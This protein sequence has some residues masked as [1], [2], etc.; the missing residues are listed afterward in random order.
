VA[1][2]IVKWAGG[3]TRLV[4]E[5][6]QRIPN[7][8]RTYA[9]PFAGGAA[10]FF[11][12]AQG[13]DAGSR[14]VRRAV[15]ADQNEE[16]IACYRA[17]KDDVGAVIDALG[18]YRYDKDLFYETRDRD[19]AK[20]DDVER[21]ARLL[22]LNRTCFNGLWRVN[23]SGRFNV[24]FGRYKNPRIVDEVRLRTASA[25]LAR[26]KL[27]RGDFAEATRGLGEGDFVY[28]DPPYAP[29]SKTAAFT[30]YARGGFDHDDQLRLVE[31]VR[32]LRER[33]ALTMLSNADTA[34]TRALYADF[35]VHVVYV[36]RP[37]NS[38]IT[39][40]GDARE[41]IV[42]SWGKKGVHEQTRAPRP[43]LR[44]SRVAAG[45]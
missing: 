42:T 24:P 11:A 1:K 36:P 10:L 34:E 19:T 37:I 14:K 18:A 25:A 3:K 45:R 16:L 2:P 4:P 38:D 9:E 31:E 21:A 12:L 20:M 41:I 7:D 35:A 33:G 29:V 30:T 23:S 8:V 43:R 22:F 44:V 26:T 32:R 40:R 39:K 6:L 17:V 13:I 5:L 27:V 15:L 28:F